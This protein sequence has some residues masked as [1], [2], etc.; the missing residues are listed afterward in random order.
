MA[1]TR[2]EMLTVSK[3]FRVKTVLFYKLIKSKYISTYLRKYVLY[4]CM[5]CKN[6]INHKI[7]ETQ[8]NA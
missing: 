4:V 7:V 1:V 8:G 3:L 5:T 6:L 2:L